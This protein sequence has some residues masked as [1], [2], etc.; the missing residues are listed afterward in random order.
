MPRPRSRE[1]MGKRLT[2]YL[3][4][5]SGRAARHDMALLARIVADMRAQRPDHIA[6][7]GDILNIGLAAE[8][9]LA[10]AW[11]K[12]LG[13]P[14]DVSFTPGNHDA[15]VR[16]ALKD[17]ARTFAPWTA[18]ETR[19]PARYPYL[20][21]RGDLALIG[22]SSGVP[23]APFIASGTLGPAQRD[24]LERLLT[25]LGEEDCA[26]V[27]MVHHPPH[28]AGATTGRGLTDS[29]A[30]EALIARAGAELIVHGHDHRYS[31]T[32]IAGARGPVPVVGAPSASAA[33]ERRAGYHLFRFER[34]KRGWTIEGRARGVTPDGAI[35][36][37]TAIPLA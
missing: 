28:G 33:G 11:L 4:W 7:T 12:T 6:M 18:S 37:V 27:I 8:F 30:F 13:A 36:D 17:L 9:P 29:R 15:Y 31:V 24:E 5:R 25:T 10:S 22:L 20:R 34:A 19:G 32:R 1:L 21:R 3:N 35:G 2:G 14:D 16:S 26:R 23:T